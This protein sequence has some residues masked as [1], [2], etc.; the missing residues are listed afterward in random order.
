MN[1]WPFGRLIWLALSN[2]TNPEKIC[3]HK[4]IYDLIDLIEVAEASIHA[5]APLR[6][7]RVFIIL[8]ALSTSLPIYELI[9]FGNGLLCVVV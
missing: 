9:S 3:L 2:S 7:L 5:S 8:E 6:N 1:P 4:G